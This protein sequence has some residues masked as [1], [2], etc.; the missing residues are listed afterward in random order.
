MA[1]QATATGQYANSFCNHKIK[2]F[3]SLL[4]S[5]VKKIR[6]VA[7][8]A[9]VRN[10]MIYLQRSYFLSVNSGLHVFYCGIALVI[11]TLRIFNICLCISFMTLNAFNLKNCY[12]YQQF[13]RDT[14]W[15]SPCM[16]TYVCSNKVLLCHYVP[17]AEAIL[18][19]LM[20][21]LPF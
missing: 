17:V 12:V 9:R 20:P 13:H 21:F 1:A 5:S 6:A 19:S 8:F 2:V 18:I 3:I 16:P 15:F 7:G 10:F 11:Q 4:S 14:Y